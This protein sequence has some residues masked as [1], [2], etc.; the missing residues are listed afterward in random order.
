MQR[1]SNYNRS[2]LTRRRDCQSN[3][4]TLIGGYLKK[5]TLLG[6]RGQAPRTVFTIIALSSKRVIGHKLIDVDVFN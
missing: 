2:N 6:G 1:R 4:H 5:K 3:S